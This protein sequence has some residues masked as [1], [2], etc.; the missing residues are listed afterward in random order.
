MLEW[1]AIS[2][3]EG[4]S[5][6]RGQTGVSNN[7]GGF[8]TTELP[9][10]MP[11]SRNRQGPCLHPK[12]RAS[13][14]EQ[15]HFLIKPGPSG[16]SAVEAVTPHPLHACR[17]L[18]GRWARCLGRPPSSKT[19]DECPVSSSPLP[20]G[21]TSGLVPGIQVLAGLASGK[22][23][24]SCS[25]WRRGRGVGRGEGGGRV[26]LTATLMRLKLGAARVTQ[27]LACP[28]VGLLVPRLGCSQA[29]RTEVTSG[30]ARP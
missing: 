13:V 1:V 21:R 29:N 20:C 30:R 16:A 10:K 24:R 17:C 22:Q 3:S 15:G 7:A 23:R 4:S 12:Y 14:G 25:G 5:Q 8:F 28:E 18:R 26:P 9:G 27:R 6:L 11:A 2:F 19:Q